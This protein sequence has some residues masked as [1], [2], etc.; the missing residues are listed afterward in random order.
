M[1]LIVLD[2]VAQD[3]DAVTD[4]PLPLLLTIPELVDDKGQTVWQAN[5]SHTGEKRVR[6]VWEKCIEIE[7]DTLLLGHI[8]AAYRGP[9]SLSL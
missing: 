6:G 3:K 4:S 1:A 5:R 2:D 9:E 7:T 8:M